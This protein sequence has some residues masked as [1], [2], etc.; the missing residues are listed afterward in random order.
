MHGAGPQINS[1]LAE[2]GVPIGAVCGYSRDHLFVG[3]A[4][5][6]RTQVVLGAL[7]PE[8]GPSGDAGSS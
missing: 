2:A 8:A 7:F 3:R 4:H 6:E 1:A 5:L